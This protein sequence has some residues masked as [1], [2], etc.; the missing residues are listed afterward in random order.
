MEG[1]RVVYA[2]ELGQ[3]MGS[4]SHKLTRQTAQKV[5][6]EQY[7][8]VRGSTDTLPCS[9][10]EVYQVSDHKTHM[11]IYKALALKDSVTKDESS[12][13]SPGKSLCRPAQ[14]FPPM[15]LSLASL[16]LGLNSSLFVQKVSF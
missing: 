10:S 15:K 12:R 13:I 8:C 2:T 16:H 6:R 1:S 4:I 11:A 7:C 14:Q 5:E 9:K 3:Y